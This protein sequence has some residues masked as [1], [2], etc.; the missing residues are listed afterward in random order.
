[1]IIDLNTIPQGVSREYD[2]CLEKNWWVPDEDNA[3]IAGIETPVKVRI[4]I[5]RSGSRFFLEGG[6][7]GV[8]Q[9]SCDRC[10][11]PFSRG[12][13]TDFSLYLTPPPE[14]L[15]RAE[16]ELLEEDMEVHFV[17]DDEVDLDDII[18]EQIYLALPLKNICDENCLGLCPKCGCNLN[19]EKCECELEKGHP[20]LSVLKNLKL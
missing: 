3:Q 2:F 8:I 6:L 5:S 15:D 18:R 20:G 4:E 7:E 9:V 12:L 19:R 17:R 16:I 1:M 13:K 11:V 10:L 14:G